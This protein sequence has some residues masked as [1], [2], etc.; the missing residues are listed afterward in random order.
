MADA[1]DIQIKTDDKLTRLLDSVERVEERLS[2][3]DGLKEQLSTYEEAFAENKARLEKLEDSGNSHRE[4]TSKYVP[5]SVDRKRMLGEW[6]SEI[7]QIAFTPGYESRDAD[8]V[9]TG[10]VTTDGGFLV[11]D[12]VAPEV[13]RIVERAGIAR[14][15][16]RV[17]PMGSDT[18]KLTSRDGA[19]TVKVLFP[20]EGVAPLEDKDEFTSVNLTAK[21]L[22]G[23]TAISD[24]LGGD[25]AIDVGAYLLEVFAEALA[26]EE[27]KQCLNSTS[28][29]T[30]VLDT[31]GVTAVDGGASFTDIDY[32]DIVKVQHSVDASL[33]D[34]GTF[35]FHPSIGEHLRNIKDTQGNP[36]WSMFAGGMEPTILGRPYAM[37]TQMPSVDATGVKSVLYGDF[38]HCVL[39][40]R[41]G[42][43]VAFSSEAGFKESNR[44]MRVSE[45]IAV[46][47]PTAAAFAYIKSS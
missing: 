12:L 24:E 47:V 45:R 37:T 6:A 10:E 26:K 17:M 32:G 34:R 19:N 20:G 18:V 9:Q 30:G 7:Y 21:K 38:S 23:L 28:P 36:I 31:V 13:I 14:S 25:A 2:E 35:V 15:L 3:V 22:V 41:D 5:D 40:I 29:F 4:F 42:F 43:S 1:P 16:C 33:I 44:W 27:D 46:A 11:P 39:G 8:D